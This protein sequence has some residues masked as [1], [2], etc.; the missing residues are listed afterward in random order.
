MSQKK[1][2]KGVKLCWLAIQHPFPD[3]P[4]NFVYPIKFP[5][6]RRSHVVSP[7]PFIFEKKKWKYWLGLVTL[8]YDARSEGGSPKTE[9][10]WRFSFLFTYPQIKYTFEKSDFLIIK[11]KYYD[12]L[13]QIK[14]HFFF[15]KILVYDPPSDRASYNRQL[16]LTW[17]PHGSN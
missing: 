13:Y 4:A 8:S 12:R 9:K 1:S 2:W 5:T 6:I 17:C 3:T 7:P 10:K 16:L 11:C 14:R 15:A